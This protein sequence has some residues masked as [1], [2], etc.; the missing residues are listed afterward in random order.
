M[1]QFV[2]AGTAAYGGASVDAVAAGA[3]AMFYLKNGVDTLITTGK[4]NFG[5]FNLVI[6]RGLEKGGPIVLPMFRYHM[7]YTRGDYKAATKFTAELTIDSSRLYAFSNYTVIVVKNGIQFNERNKWTATVC[8]GLNPDATK[9]AAALAKHLQ[10]NKIGHGLDVK[11]VGSKLIF[12]CPEA[13]KDYTIVPADAL[14]GLDVTMKHAE[15]AYGD[16]AYVQDLHEKAWAGFGYND[17]YREPYDLMYPKHDLNDTV[18]FDPNNK[19]FTI[20]TIRFAEPREM[21]T[22]DEVVH[23]IVQVAFPT[24]ATG[25]EAFETALKGMVDEN[26]LAGTNLC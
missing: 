19:G 4:E 26:G 15:A 17:M 20:F 7:S 21:K 24:G 18:S 5:R 11:A 9:I 8:A 3:P 2:L 1:R 25:I 10:N 23:Q 6:G 13:G 14:T 16:A 12:E 22:R